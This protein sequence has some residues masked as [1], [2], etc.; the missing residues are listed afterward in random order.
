MLPQQT[1]KVCECKYEGSSLDINS[2]NPTFVIQNPLNGFWAKYILGISAHS[3]RN[4]FSEDNFIAQRLLCHG[5]RELM[6]LSVML[7]WINRNMS[8]IAHIYILTVLFQ[9]YNFEIFLFNFIILSK[10][11]LKGSLPDK[12]TLINKPK[13]RCDLEVYQVLCETM[14]RAVC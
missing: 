12:I 13:S 7:Q 1:L 2:F 11:V 8:N 3:V 10:Q 14:K 6:E 5:S 9:S 4:V